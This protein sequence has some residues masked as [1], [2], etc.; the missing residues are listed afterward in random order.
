MVNGYE[1]V[2]GGIAQFKHA[3]TGLHQSNE[4]MEGARCPIVGTE[5]G[6]VSLW[7]I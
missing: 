1:E 2:D 4:F 3:N 5:A 6:G 7:F